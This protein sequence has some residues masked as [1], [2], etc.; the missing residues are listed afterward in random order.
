MNTKTQ[1]NKVHRE[2]VWNVFNYFTMILYELIYRIRYCITL[3]IHILNA[4]SFLEKESFQRDN[5][6]KIDENWR[7]ILSMKFLL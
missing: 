7:E 4:S 6:M 5:E 2:I 3:C 1:N